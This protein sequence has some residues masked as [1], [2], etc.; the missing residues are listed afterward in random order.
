M[1]SKPTI[2]VGRCPIFV[3][4]VSSLALFHWALSDDQLSSTIMPSVLGTQ[5][6]G[7]L[8]VWVLGRQAPMAE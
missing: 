3:R 6:H 5:A 7:T 1:G 4:I 8:R 2:P